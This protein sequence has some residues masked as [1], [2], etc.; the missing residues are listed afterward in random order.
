MYARL[1]SLLSVH[2]L[3]CPKTATSAALHLQLQQQAK[4]SASV[5]ERLNS[6]EEAFELL[7]LVRRPTYTQFDYFW[8]V[9]LPKDQA[10]TLTGN[11]SSYRSFLFQSM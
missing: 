6:A 3:P 4:A 2:T 5:L 11:A 10:D 1:E 8:R 9:S 7:F